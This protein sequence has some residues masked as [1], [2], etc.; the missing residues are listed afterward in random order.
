MAAGWPT[1]C[2]FDEDARHQPRR[3]DIWLA[4][5]LVSTRPYSVHTCLE[6]SRIVHVD[7]YFRREFSL[8]ILALT[9]FRLL[10]C[11]CVA[12]AK[13]GHA[14]LEDGFR[15]LRWMFTCLNLVIIARNEHD[16]LFSGH[17]SLSRL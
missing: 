1:S 10:H 11:R 2:R 3:L 15:I 4:Y 9:L 13:N 8:H 12:L 16:G 6:T 7:S 14:S 17:S 5:F